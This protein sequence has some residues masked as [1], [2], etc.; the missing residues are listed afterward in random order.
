MENKTIKKV[1]SLT[2]QLNQINLKLANAKSDKE[3][4]TLLRQNDILVKKRAELVKQ[5]R[6]SK[7]LIINLNEVKNEII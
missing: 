5:L 4:K 1:H 7:K 2:N 6:Q 3:I